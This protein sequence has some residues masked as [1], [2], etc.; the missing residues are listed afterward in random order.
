[1]NKKKIPYSRQS[2]SKLDIK[3]VV[4]TL[5]SDFLTSGPQVIKFEKEIQKYLKVKYAVCVNSA[6]SALHISCMVLGLGKKDE[7]WTSTNSFVA[8][9]NCGEFC[10]AK[11]DLVDINLDDFNISLEKLEK[12]LINKKSPKIVIPVHLAG[13]PSDLKKIFYLSKK[14]NF[15][16]L[17]DASHAFGSEYM[18]SKIGSCK[19]SD[20]AVFSFH[21]VKIFTSGEGGVLV[22]NNKSYYEKALMLRNHGITKDKK[23][24]HYKKNNSIYYEQ[25]ILGYNYRLSDL[26]AALGSSQLKKIHIFEKLRFKIKR[27]Y[28]QKL[29]KLPL[30]FPKYKNTNFSNHLYIVLIDSTKTKKKRDSLIKFLNKKMIT[31]SVHYI[32]IHKQPYYKKYNFLSKNFRNS[33]F[34]YNNAI[35]LPIFPYLTT[36]KQNYIIK[37]IEKFFQK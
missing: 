1:M 14:H 22:T 28:D 30:L 26:H 13:Y 23:K 24:Y 18:K 5:K 17:E 8:S 16:I 33:N 19:Y 25:Q 2:I 35:S 6:T 20:I 34:Y 32:P 11:L 31:T 36:E 7:F 27:R 21:P 15:K 12:K 10:G 9:A 29:N 4:K 37:C 3:E